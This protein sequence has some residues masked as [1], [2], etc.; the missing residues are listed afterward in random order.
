MEGSQTDERVKPLELFFDLVFVFG[1][2]QV[3]SLLSADPT[4]GGLVRGLAVLAAIWWAWAAYAWLT[5]TLNPEEGIVRIA[6]FVVMAAMLVVALAVPEAFDDHGVIFGVAYLVVRSMHLA[7]Y[8]LAARGDPDLLGAVL[9]MT[10]SS[11]ISGVLILGAGFT[12]GTERTA[13][14][15]IA[16]AIDYLGV[17]V[18]RGQGWRLSPGHFA[19]RH[20]LIVIIAIGESIV[21][22]GVGAAGTPLSAGVITAAVLGMTVAAALWWT[23]FDWVAIV[24]EQQLRRTT[25]AQQATLARD[26][27]SYLH[28][29]MVAGI[30]LFATSMKKTLAA[31]DEQLGPVPVAALCGGLALYLLAHVLLRLRISGV[32]GT[33]VSFLRRVGRGRPLA[34]L[35]LLVF[36]PF[37]GDMPSLAALTVVAAIF[38]IL[39]AYEAIVY[40][41]P[42]ARIRQGEIATQETMARGPVRATQ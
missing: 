35:A 8:A 11:T 7:L 13:L 17:I 14:W 15:L 23:Y 41:E 36:W 18:G 39:I 25:G 37:A 31:V 24:V 29:A 32:I 26:A 20:G 4:W 19:E 28:F 3:T 10:P 30:V 5:N 9:R 38:V 40:R 16:L 22:L 12:E 1:L 34:M 2:T 6:M 33:Q 21:A 27:Y 42:R